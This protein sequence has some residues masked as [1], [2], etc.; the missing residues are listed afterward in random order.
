MPGTKAD[1]NA[2]QS[3]EGKKDEQ[4]QAPVELKGLA[5]L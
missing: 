5:F 3:Q 1:S 4:I 2:P